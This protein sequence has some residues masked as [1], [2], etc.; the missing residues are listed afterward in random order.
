M[1][2]HIVNQ[3]WPESLLHRQSSMATVMA[4]WSIKYDTNWY[5]VNQVI[6]QS[7]LHSKSSMVSYLCIVNQVWHSKLHGQSN[8]TLTAAFSSSK[9]TITA[10]WSTKYDTR[11]YL[12]NQVWP[13]ALVYESMDTVTV[14]WSIK[15]DTH[16]R[17]VNQ[18]W[19]QSLLHSQ[20]S[21]TLAV[22]WSINY[23]TYSC[24][25]NQVQQQVLLHGQSSV[26]TVMARSLWL[27][28]HE[29]GCQ[30]LAVSVMLNHCHTLT[31]SSLHWQT[32]VQYKTES[33]QGL[34]KIISARCTNQCPSS[35]DLQCC[36]D[37]KPQ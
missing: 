11:W 18:V 17:M 13:Q 31:H 33:N 3:V 22:A 34:H 21:M 16:W 32:L 20:S 4:A 6:P 36:Q 2:P 26:T 37:V 23:D 1:V 25:V 24:I 15:Y 8:M 5:M 28:C 12:V 27:G 14:A 35:Y 19:S 7:V 9:A 29:H 30:T 10:A